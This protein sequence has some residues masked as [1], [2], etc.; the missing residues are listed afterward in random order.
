MKLT[1]REKW[2]ATQAVKHLADNWCSEGIFDWL[3][4]NEQ[5]LADE[6]PANKVFQSHEGCNAFWEYWQENGESGKHGVY[7]STWGALRAYFDAVDS[8]NIYY[9]HNIHLDAE[10]YECA[11]M[12]LDDMKIPR[13]DESSKVYSLVGRIYCLANKA[14]PTDSATGA[15]DEQD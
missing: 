3:E 9:H 11:M 7:E 14:P 15:I 2:I 5:R 6:A 13:A 8:Q 10:E 12:V 4:E 1:E